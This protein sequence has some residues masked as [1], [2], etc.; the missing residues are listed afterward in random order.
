MNNT[1]V[2]LIVQGSDLRCLN[3]LQDC[4]FG[5]WRLLQTSLD[6]DIIDLIG[7]LSDSTPAMNC[8]F[9]IVITLQHL[10]CRSFVTILYLYDAAGGEVVA[11]PLI[12][13]QTHSDVSIRQTLH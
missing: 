6:S 11:H 9:I 8:I 10:G 1:T 2:Y 4:I 12:P 7:M 5:A 13:G 3:Q